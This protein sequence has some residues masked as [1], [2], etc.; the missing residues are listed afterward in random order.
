[1]KQIILSLLILASLFTQ[2]LNGFV[3]YAISPRLLKNTGI[4]NT[5]DYVINESRIQLKYEHSSDEGELFFKVDFINDNVLNTTSLKVREAYFTATPFEWLDIKLGRQ[6][7][8]WG[9]GDLMFINDVFQ[10]DWISFFSGRSDEYLKT[11]S[12][13]IRL[14]AYPEMLG[15]EAFDLSIMPNSQSDINIQTE[16]RFRSVNPIFAAYISSGITINNTLPTANAQKNAEFALRIKLKNIAGFTPSLYAYKGRWNNPYSMLFD[17]IS[18]I[19]PFFSKLNVYGGSLRGQTLGGILSLETGFYDSRD[20]KNGDNPLIEN[21]SFRFLALFETSL[22]TTLDLGIQYYS[23]IIQDYDKIEDGFNNP[24]GF[25]D[26]DGMRDE[27][28]GLF[29]LRLTQKLLNETLWLTWFSYFSPTDEDYFFRPRVKYEYSDNIR[30]I[31]TANIFDAFGDNNDK[32]KSSNG[33]PDYHNTMFGQFNKDKNINFTF[34]YI[35]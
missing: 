2:E 10:K 17:G 30:F 11:A 20:D 27:V 24:V 32:R 18:Q 29:T 28:R 14:T 7:Q 34:R 9:V 16:G 25:A 8:T 19:T 6:I 13:A 5:K 31:F 4:S 1:M 35:F 15:I 23:E 22:T 33:F 26:K 12:D 21:S 3:E